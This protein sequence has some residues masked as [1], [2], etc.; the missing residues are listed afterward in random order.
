MF[1]GRRDD[2]NGNVITDV[3]V[4]KVDGEYKEKETNGEITCS[5]T[6]FGE[7]PLPN[8]DKQCICVPSGTTSGN[9]SA[10]SSLP[11]TIFPADTG[12]PQVIYKEEGY[13]ELLTENII[14]AI[15]DSNG[16]L[17]EDNLRL[18]NNQSDTP[19]EHHSLGEARQNLMNFNIHADERSTI[20]I[21][22]YYIA[23]S[24]NNEVSI[25]DI[26]EDL[27]NQISTLIPN[28]KCSDNKDPYGS[29]P[30][31]DD[32]L[33]LDEPSNIK[34]TYE[35]K[36]LNSLDRNDEKNYCNSNILKCGCNPFIFGNCENNTTER[37]D[38]NEYSDLCKFH[39]KQITIDD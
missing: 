12:G 38:K 31:T 22:S 5:H 26:K 23:D 11:Q 29:D 20:G 19:S 35:N 3:N 21:N 9:F 16:Q 17:I 1:C 37:F 24:V 13:N 28:I 30:C 32:K 34:L 39:Y 18:L 8:V 14:P 6:T 27:I 33:E 36:P 4:L 2:A 25:D 15:T 10:K 7:D